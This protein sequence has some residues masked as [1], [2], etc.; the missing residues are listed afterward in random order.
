MPTL[1][2]QGGKHEDRMDLYRRDAGADDR[3]E[4]RMTNEQFLVLAGCIWLAPHIEKP[5]AQIGSSVMF[6]V[7]SAI[8]LGWKP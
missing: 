8:V 6:I 2:E 4:L 3:Q 7:A 5:F 1:S